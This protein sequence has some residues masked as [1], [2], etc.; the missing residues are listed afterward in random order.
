MDNP[1]H[2]LH[3]MRIRIYSLPE[4]ELLLEQKLVGVVRTL[5]LSMSPSGWHLAAY[6]LKGP[7]EGE[8]CRSAELTILRF[9]DPNPDYHPKIEV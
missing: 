2:I 1:K 4:G 5:D 9:P 7:G 6:V 3:R 8:R